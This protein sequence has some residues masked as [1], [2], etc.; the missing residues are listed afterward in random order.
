MKLIL[1]A[2]VIYILYS[3]I[4]Q[5]DEEAWSSFELKLPLSFVLAVVL[6]VPN[7]WIA[8]L[9]WKLTLS[10]IGA[11]SDYK[12][13]IQSFF[14]GVVTG[15]LTPNMLGNFIGRFYYFDRKHRAQITAFTMLSN[16][17]QFLASITFGTIAIFIIGELLI[18][19][20]SQELATWLF[21]GVLI[22]YLIYFFIDNFLSRFKKKEFTH[23]FKEILKRNR[24][25][26]I[27]IL[28]LS[29]SRFA[30][31]TLQFSLM[32]NAFGA[33]WNLYLI[34]AIWQVYLIAMLAP[35]LF[36]GKIGIKESIALFV[37]GGLGL[38]DVSILFS[39]LLIW[40]VNSMSPA[41]VGFVV[42]RNKGIE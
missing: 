25:Y 23:E 17:A 5:F 37:L 39:S 14:A 35:S 22:S 33:D 16:F 21:V 29:Y 31:F 26:R 13:R 19:K 7:I 15:M 12:S 9:K 18:L 27:K 40:F 34:A 4:S 28:G 32:L 10:T 38:N 1:F 41:L 8:F 6:V 11:Q 24:T 2:G 36:L 42:C 30:I 3:Q 20:D